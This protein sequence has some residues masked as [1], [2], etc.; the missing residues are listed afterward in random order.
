MRLGSS[1]RSLE[2]EASAGKL[3]QFII[4]LTVSVRPGVYRWFKLKTSIE[5]DEIDTRAQISWPGW[6]LADRFQLVAQM[7]YQLTIGNSSLG[8]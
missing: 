8:F 3:S 1:N 7:Y 6:Q 4:V 5:G 2:E